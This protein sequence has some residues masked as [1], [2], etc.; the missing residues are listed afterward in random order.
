MQ[1][2]NFEIQ[3]FVCTL[4]RAMSTAQRKARLLY[5]H[6]SRGCPYFGE[7]DMH[8]CEVILKC[9]KTFVSLCSKGCDFFQE[10]TP[11][12][13]VSSGGKECLCDGQ[14]VHA[15]VLSALVFIEVIHTLSGLYQTVV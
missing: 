8:P 1:L 15:F 13:I 11:R 5:P 3:T 10:K 2:D 6:A 9:A 14:G 7:K 12:L 4:F